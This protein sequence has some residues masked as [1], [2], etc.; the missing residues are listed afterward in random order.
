MHVI[1]GELWVFFPEE[2]YHLVKGDFM[3]VPRL[4]P[5]WSWNPSPKRCELFEA[6]APLLDPSEAEHGQALLAGGETF[7]PPHIARTFWAPGN[8]VERESDLMR[9][10]S[11]AA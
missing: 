2:A 6:H 7:V 1:S 8:L 9:R 3:R 10:S 4:A 5:H 11:S